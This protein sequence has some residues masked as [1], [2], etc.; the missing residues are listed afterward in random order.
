MS[1]RASRTLAILALSVIHCTGSAVAARGDELPQRLLPNSLFAM[2][3]ALHVPAMTPTAQAAL[4]K[5]LGYAGSQY[6]GTLEDLDATLLAMDKADLDVFTVAVIPYDVPVDPG[7]TYPPVLKDTI[8]KLQGRSALVLFQ[9][10][11]ATY[12]RSAAEGD[13]RAIA[14]GRELADYAKSYDVRLAVYPHVNIW[15]ERVDHATRIV[16]RCQRDN[17][18]ICF[19]QFHWLRTDP[20]GNLP[21]LVRQAMPH[22]LLVTI[23]GAASDGAY[24]TLDQ[25]LAET[26]SF[27]KPFVQQGYR[28]PI[29]LQCVG[30]PGAPRDNLSRC[31]DAWREIS[32][33]LAPL[34]SASP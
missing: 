17:L 29:G 34:T 18:G 16:Q 13:E 25:G 26:E 19:N 33:R 28:G 22:L 31:M 11:S 3:F 20:D 1:R 2:N 12:E 9:F 21:E 14:L 15:C 32:S 23:N 27:L 10:V 8:R 5:D 6:L 24:A 30:I 4:L 7:A